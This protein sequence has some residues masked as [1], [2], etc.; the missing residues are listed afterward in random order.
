M[1][2]SPHHRQSNL[3]FESAVKI[4]KKIAK[5]NIENCFKPYEALLDQHDTPTVGGMKTCP[6]QRFLN[7]RTKTIIPMKA[8]LLTPELADKVLKRL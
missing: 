8:T 5:K 4:V 2:S 6:V 1:K 3:K 7:R